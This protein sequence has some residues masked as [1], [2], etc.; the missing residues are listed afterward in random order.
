MDLSAAGAGELIALACG[1]VAAGLLTGFLAGFLGIGG[2][3]IVAP[4][5]YEV[6]RLLDVGGS[7]RMHLAVGTTLAVM[8]PTSLRAFLAHKARG[9]VD[10]GAFRRLAPP[11][12]AGVILGAAVARHAPETALKWVWVAFSAVMSLWLIA[13]TGQHRLGD[14]LPR[15]GAGRWLTDAYATGVGA[16]STLLSIGGAA[17]IAALL[18]LF[19]RPIERAVATSSGIGT[20]V[21]IPGTLGFVWAGWGAAGMPPLTLGYVNLVGI[22]A[23]VPASVLAAPWGVL[24]AHGVPRRALE[25]ALAALLAVIGLRFLVGLIA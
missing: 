5:L 24:A 1:L 2:G 16:V 11:V 22:A 23:L 20:L 15:A 6:F 9:A 25:I 7:Q 19:G 21:S 12:L 8:I 14:E 4:V 17:F 10:M 18:R 3:A 13:G